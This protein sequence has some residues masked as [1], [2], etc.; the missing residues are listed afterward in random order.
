LSSGSGSQRAER[1]VARWLGLAAFL[2]YLPFVHGH[3][4]GT[5]EM[6]VFLTTR[7]LY[8]EG[9]FEVRRGPHRFR[10]REGR[11]YAHFAPGLPLVALPLYALGDVADRTLPETSVRALSG[12]PREGGRIDTLGSPQAFAVSLYPAAASAAL[13][14]LFF[15][16]Q[17]RLGASVESA[18]LAS[19]LLGGGTYVATHSVY[20]LR[21]T[22]EAITWLASF[23]ALLGYRESRRPGD[24]ALASA[25]ASLTLLVS[26]PA[27]VGIP[28]LAGYGLFLAGP[29][30]VRGGTGQRARVLAAGLLPALAAVALHAAHNQ[31]LWGAFFESPMVAQR[32]GFTTPLSVGLAGFLLSPGVSL[33][34]YSPPLLLLPLWL[35]G[36]WRERRAECVTA[37][38][39]SLG[40]LLFCAG[41]S[42]WHGLW[43]APGPRYLFLLTPLLLLPLGRWLDAHAGRR[44]RRALLALGA[45][46]LAVQLVLVLSRWSAVIRGMGYAEAAERGDLSFLWTPAQSPLAGSVRALAEGQLDTWWLGLATGTG[47]APAVPGA[48]ALLLGAWLGAVVFVGFRL[49]SRLRVASGPGSARGA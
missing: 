46:G 37:L 5:D 20:F 26:V 21:H 33:F 6:G 41:F 18:A 45:V 31:A 32:H 7:A 16:V 29:D 44:G 8:E 22:T 25:W 43:S 19:A 27:T 36:F 17:R 9:S 14:A 23:L 11:T 13:V 47:G 2:A 48:A 39:A 10:G 4:T 12:R 34:V 40:L 49:A 30:L 42:L 1:R 38:V 24:L 35:P 28:A 15:L 3:F